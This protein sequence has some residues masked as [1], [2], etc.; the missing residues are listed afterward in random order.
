MFEPHQEYHSRLTVSEGTCLHVH[1][2]IGQ[3]IML[4]IKLVFCVYVMGGAYQ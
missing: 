2:W 3:E 1:A 4:V